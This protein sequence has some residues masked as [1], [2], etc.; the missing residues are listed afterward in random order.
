MSRL[1]FSVSKGESGL[2][3]DKFLMNRGL[4]PSRVSIQK[5]IQDGCV[6]VNGLRTKSAHRLKMGDLL[7]LE[8]PELTITSNETLEP[9][10]HPLDIIHEDADLL[11]VSKPA[12]MVTHPG[13][14]NRAQ[15]LVNALIAIRPEIAGVGH[16]LRPG[17]VHRLDRETSGLLLIAKNESAYHLLTGLFKQRRMEKHYRALTFGKWPTQSGRIDLAL[18]RDPSDRKKISI[19]ARKSR[20][21]ITLYR[22]IK[23]GSNGA[24]L[25]VQILTGR[26]HQIRVHL[27]SEHHPIVGDTKYGGANWNRIPDAGLRAKLKQTSFFGLHSF[28]LRFIHPTTHAEILLECP[29][30]DSWNEALQIL[31]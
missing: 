8:K 29:L 12:G 26:T 3:V 21:A 4:S 30:P 14:G 15:T 1:S 31:A 27:S 5:W 22:V 16:S 6:F 9:W 28:S 17:I 10:N 19:R 2:R 13:A 24:L 7:E 23:Q 18:G 11:A 20:S 25:D